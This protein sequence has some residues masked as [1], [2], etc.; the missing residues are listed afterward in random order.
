M[1][2]AMIPILLLIFLLSANVIVFGSR[3]T[4]GPNQI[5]LVLSAFVAGLIAWR[6]G[7][8]WE[9]VEEHMLKSI[10]SAMTAML[11]LMVIG[12]LS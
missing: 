4:E 12:A 1:T 8:K 9:E 2:Q 7:K 11:I 5:A 6:A 10:N 3:S